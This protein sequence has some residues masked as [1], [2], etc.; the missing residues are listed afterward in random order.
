M[1]L[2]EE[3]EE[4][5]QRKNSIL[6]MERKANKRRAKWKHIQKELSTSRRGDDQTGKCFKIT[7]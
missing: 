3:I 6:K 2:K 7:F 1:S 5:K 4:R